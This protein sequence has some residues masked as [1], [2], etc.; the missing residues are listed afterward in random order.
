MS[1]LSRGEISV[2]SYPLSRNP[3]NY[4]RQDRN[5]RD[6][7]FFNGISGCLLSRSMQPCTPVSRIINTA[8]C[9]HEQS[10]SF[11]PSIVLASVTAFLLQLLTARHEIRR[12]S[13]NNVK[14]LDP[15]SV[16]LRPTL[17]VCGK[18]CVVPVRTAG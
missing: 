3:G 13:P 18:S 14:H 11:S 9:L 7:S 4:R 6:T 15:K 12:H 5:S 1:L 17:D 10:Q 2:G 8:V 16:T